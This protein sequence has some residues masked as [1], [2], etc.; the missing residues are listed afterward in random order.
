MDSKRLYRSCLFKP[1]PLILSGQAAFYFK[2]LLAFLKRYSRAG[3]VAGVFFGQVS[4]YMLGARSE[5]ARLAMRS[6]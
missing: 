3:E 2:K 4:I 5:P 1:L 6:Q